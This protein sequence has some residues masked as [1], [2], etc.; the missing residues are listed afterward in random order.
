[1][2]K[3]DIKIMKLLKKCQSCENK[4]K[5]YFSA[6]CSKCVVV[7]KRKEIKENEE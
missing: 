6:C 3:T 1:M 5:P 2:T 4:D 7:H